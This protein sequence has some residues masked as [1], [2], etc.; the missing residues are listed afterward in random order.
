MSVKCYGVQVRRLK[1]TFSLDFATAE[2]HK[3]RKAINNFPLLKRL[4][5]QTEGYSNLHCNAHFSF[6]IPSF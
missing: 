2:V 4:L 1:S 6:L 3:G 5:R